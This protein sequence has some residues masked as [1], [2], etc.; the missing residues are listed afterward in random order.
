VDWGCEDARRPDV[1]PCRNDTLSM[2]SR[3]MSAIISSERGMRTEGRPHVSGLRFA[4]RTAP[5]RSLPHS[6]NGDERMFESRS[7]PS[8][9]TRG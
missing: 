6:D 8:G 4:A 3:V 5:A 7:R 1:K 2:P 9:R